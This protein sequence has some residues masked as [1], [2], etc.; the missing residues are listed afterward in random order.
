[1]L[2]ALMEITLCFFF[3]REKLQF[4]FTIIFTALAARETGLIFL[5]RFSARMTNIFRE[6]KLDGSPVAGVPAGLVVAPV[7]LQLHTLH[8]N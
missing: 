1:M 7:W 5:T 8:E 2:K 3:V 4:F 6:K